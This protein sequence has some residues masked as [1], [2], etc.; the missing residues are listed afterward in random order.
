[1]DA[2]IRLAP[3]VAAALLGGACS[4]VEADDDAIETGARGWFDLP[5]PER[6][7]VP[8]IFATLTPIV[9]YVGPDGIGRYRLNVYF[10]PGME[11]VYDP[12]RTRIFSGWEQDPS[13]YP[14]MTVTWT[15]ELEAEVEVDFRVAGTTGDIAFAGLYVQHCERLSA[16]EPGDAPRCEPAWAW[17]EGLRVVGTPTSALTP[18]PLLPSPLAVGERRPMQ[19]F[20]PSRDAGGEVCV[21]APAPLRYAVA[22]PSIARVDAS[23]V[24]EGLRPGDTELIVSVDAGG[25]EITARTPISV[26]THAMGPPAPGHLPLLDPAGGWSFERRNELYGFRS[27]NAPLALR[28]DGSPML[29]VHGQVRVTPTTG[30]TAPLT[31]FTWSGSGFG[32]EVVSDVFEATGGESVVVDPNGHEYLVWH[33]EAWSDG[34]HGVSVGPGLQVL[35]RPAGTPSGGWR[36]RR[37]SVWVDPP[38]PASG[39]IGNDAAASRFMPAV[40]THPTE[41]VWVYYAGRL[42]HVTEDDIVYDDIDYLARGWTDFWEDDPPF[43]GHPTTGERIDADLGP[44]PEGFDAPLVRIGALLLGKSQGQWRELP[45]HGP[46]RAWLDQWSPGTPYQGPTWT[47]RDLQIGGQGASSSDGQRWLG[48][49]SAGPRITEQGVWPD[50][51]AACQHLRHERGATQFDDGSAWLGF[52]AQDGLALSLQWLDPLTGR[53]RTSYDTIPELYLADLDAE[54]YA[55]PTDP[56]DAGRVAPVRE[57]RRAFTMADGTLILTEE[58]SFAA[59]PADD[60]A[61]PRPW[62][63]AEIAPDTGLLPGWDIGNG[64][65]WIMPQGDAL[66]LFVLHHGKLRVYRAPTWK[67]PFRPVGEAVIG[68]QPV[69]EVLIDVERMPDG[70]FLVLTSLYGNGGGTDAHALHVDSGGVLVAPIGVPSGTPSVQPVD[71]FETMALWPD[72]DGGLYLVRSDGS[73]NLHFARFKEGAWSTP[74]QVPMPARPFLAHGGALGDVLLVPTETTVFAVTHA[75]ELGAP[76]REL[77]STPSEGRFVHLSDGRGAWVGS[78]PWGGDPR[79]SAAQVWLTADGLRWS[80]PTRVYAQGGARQ[81][82]FAAAAGPSG[83]LWSNFGDNL[84]SCLWHDSGVTI[85]MVRRMWP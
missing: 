9:P 39:E 80:E 32:V 62:G 17:A 38:H 20:Y 12:T 66:V 71:A 49:A 42:A 37:L 41:G 19:V 48:G 3:V 4:W 60:A 7:P 8:P 57:V 76:D 50:F 40:Q 54:P 30:C 73:E 58:S 44:Q 63:R 11:A 22:D 26:G 84:N 46:Y 13:L 27:G 74:T 69:T 43:A 59:I 64:G 72:G 23:G 36:R 51:A 56:L 85:P 70:R 24:V 78:A 15:G 1:M 34:I 82:A 29:L 68:P 2:L 52:H 6:E 67:S 25:Q 28:P 79:T 53:H 61:A 65:Q 31:L 47:Q 16:I 81:F 14:G 75:G 55:R 18:V 5:A 21:F 77:P 33:D 83:E 45:N 35:D 10:A